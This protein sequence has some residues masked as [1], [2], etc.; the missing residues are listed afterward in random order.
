MAFN[1]DSIDVA[2]NPALDRLDEYNSGAYNV[3]TNPRGFAGGGHISQFPAALLDATIVANAF[4]EFA[5]LMSGYADA[6][7]ASATSAAS[8]AANLTGS[9]VSS[10]AL[11]ASGT[12]TFTTQAGKTFSAGT[13]LLCTSDANPTTHWMVIHVTSYVSTTLQGSVLAFAGSGSRADWTIRPTG[14][15]AFAGMRY[16]WSTNT[17]SSDP[18]SGAIKINN[19][20]PASATAVYISETDFDG[21]ALGSVIATW[22]DSTSTLRGR[23]FIIQSTN[24]ANFI[25][26]DIASNITD[27]GAWDAFSV[28]YVASGGTLADGALVSLLFL[29]QA[30]KGDTGPAG[31]SYA[32]TSTTSLAIGTGSKVFTTQAGL[33]YQTAARARATDSGNSANWMEGVVTSYSGSTLTIN[34]DLTSGSGTVASWLINIA[35]ERGATGA[36]GAVGDD[37]GFEYQFNTATSGDPGAGKFRFNNATFGSATIVAISETD[38]NAN[39]LAALFAAIDDGT[40]TNKALV[41][42]IEQGGVSHFSFYITS[43]LTDQGS[44]DEFNITPIGSSGSISNNDV[45]HIIF[46]PL[47]KGDAGTTGSA[48]PTTAPTWVFDTVDTSDSD[49][50]TNK[51]KLNNVT[52]SSVTKAFINDTGLGSADITNFVLSWDDSTNSTHRGTLFIVQADDPT[53]W[54][55]FTVGTVADDGAYLDV[56]LTYVAGPGGFTDES[57]CAFSFTRSGNAGAGSGD[58][59]GPGSA[60]D[61]RFAL[62]DGGTGK[63]IKEHTGAPGSLAVLNT[64]GTSQI[65]NDAVDNSKLANMG[66]GTVKGRAAGAG[67]GDP[68]DRTDAQLKIDMAFVKGDV[69]LSN[70]D[71]TSDANKPVSTAQA[72]VNAIKKT[73]SVRAATTAN[74]TIATALNDADTLDGV[75]LANGDLVLVKDQSSQSENGIYVVAVSPARHGEYDAYND[76]PGA[77]VSV[78]EGTANAD[79]A[80]RCTSNVGGTIDSTALQFVQDDITAY[81]AGG[82]LALSGHQFSVNTA[83]AFTWSA[84]HIF[85]NSSGLRI[86]DSGSDHTLGIIVGTNFSADRTLTIIPG[87]ASRTITLGGNVTT[88]APFTLSGAFSSTFTFSNTTTV[89]FPTS[90]TLATTA[91]ASDTASGLVELAT[92]AETTTGT[93]ATRAVTP[94]GLAGSDY[95]KHLVQIAV[96]DP[97]SSSSLTT[98]D[99]KAYFRVPAI[100]N[101]YNLVAVASSVTTN[102]TSGLPTVQLRRVRSGSPVDMLSTSLTIDANEGDSSTAATAAVINTS[103]DDVQTGDKIH[104]DVDVAGTGTKG[105]SVEMTFQLP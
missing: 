100:M 32:A 44:Y 21:N 103:N 26:L 62:F 58:V 9:S 91:A 81:T 29:P 90:G 78:Q 99:G 23:L 40:G 101:G 75:A 4:P 36:A 25:I 17:S 2:V 68:S 59:V 71:N 6:A 76:H 102:S 8:A 67:T 45:F 10:V 42:A 47:Q 80:W 49:P 73:V 87:D 13:Q 97:N 65:D 57:Q 19:A 98:G 69:G 105:L 84:A 60:N 7:S 3:T 54:G 48:G 93:D 56:G 1:W 72:A 51:F 50:G 53:K 15:P 37:A 94:D 104:I 30:N 63:L 55:I 86:Y 35:G 70:V 16:A 66:Q 83:F 92:S 74:I 27:N 33:G 38:G 31:A 22:D 20:A 88:A 5:D 12:K 18:G 64:V 41:F 61:G 28:Q 24:R 43:T 34:V 96:H 82:G 39:T 77:I 95:G 46:V 14:Y 85:P 52:F 79:T 89:T 11:T